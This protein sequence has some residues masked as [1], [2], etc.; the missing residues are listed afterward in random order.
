MKKYYFLDT[1]MQLRNSEELVLFHK[2]FTI[3]AEEAALVTDFL[4]RCYDEECLSYPGQAPPFNAAAALWAAQ[5]V[6]F[7]AQLYLFRT[8]TLKDL[9]GLFPEPKF[10][11]DAGAI[12]SAD[13]CLRFLPKLI[14]E[15]RYADPEDPLCAL[16]A[17][18]L[19]PFHYSAIGTKEV[20]IDSINWEQEPTDSCYRYLYLNRIV[21]RKDLERAAVPYW[22]QSI[23]DHLGAYKTTFWKA[24]I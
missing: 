10:S 22:K 24:L 1:L 21:E 2:S 19:V 20:A 3:D 11:A 9:A 15:L 7:T 23:S 16:L 17:R 14:Q 18:R 5:T 4:E 8:D 13:L 6:Y 12:L